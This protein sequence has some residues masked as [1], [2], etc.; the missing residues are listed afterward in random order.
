MTEVQLQELTDKL[1]EY[2]E[3]FDNHATVE[4]ERWRHLVETQ[5]KNATI[6]NERWLHSSEIQHNNATA[7]TQLVGVTSDLKKS[8]DKIAESTK[9]AVEAHDTAMKTAKG[10]GLISAAI[11]GTSATIA[12]VVGVVELLNK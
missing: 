4:D 9:G 7:I 12:A 6:E 11:I 10:L 2:I 1:N 8:L 5:Q 3:K